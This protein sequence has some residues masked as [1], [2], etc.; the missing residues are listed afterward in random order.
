MVLKTTKFGQINISGDKVIDFIECIPG[1]DNSKRYIMIKITET[2]PLYWLQ[3]VDEE[4]LAL[5]VINP[6]EVMND[7]SP[8]IDNMVLDRLQLSGDNEL[9]VV[10]VAL[11]PADLMKSTVNL[12]APILINVVRN[13]GIQTILNTGEYRIRHPLFDNKANDKAE[14]AKKNAGTDAKG[15]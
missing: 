1:F 7:Y 2:L 12:A 14:G 11:L 6:F 10:N 5:P 8:M 15:K 13:L 3:S 9:L 4:D